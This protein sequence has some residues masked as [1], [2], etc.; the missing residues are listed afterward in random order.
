MTSVAGHK[1]SRPKK[2]H[3]TLYPQGRRLYVRSDLI[4]FGPPNGHH[5][6]FLVDEENGKK[7]LDCAVCEPYL[8]AEANFYGATPNPNA[9][10]LTEDEQLEMEK[11]K[12]IN[13]TTVREMAQAMALA[14]SGALAAKHI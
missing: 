11:G 10:P 13:E 14:A 3:T 1:V 4:Q 12:L 7:Y 6:D 2:G 8:R 9:V 5:H